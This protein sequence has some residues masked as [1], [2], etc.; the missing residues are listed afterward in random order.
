MPHVVLEN[1]GSLSEVHER[2]EP[3]MEQKEGEI[4][5]TGD[6]FLNQKGTSSL[7]ECIVIEGAPPL[8]FFVQLNRKGENIT[9]RLLPRT[10][11]EKTNGVKKLMGLIAKRIRD[12][13]P[14]S[15]YGK[16]NLQDFLA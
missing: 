4:L 12:I 5:K 1:T 9:V 10:D 16:T 15:Q 13:F 14:E 7:V 8:N 11:P 2:L 6:I 3:V